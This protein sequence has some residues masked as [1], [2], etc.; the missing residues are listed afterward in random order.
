M[1]FLRKIAP[2]P[3]VKAYHYIL[4]FTAAC[5][6]RFPS[7]RIAVI[8]VTG[9][10]GKSTVVELVSA[11]LEEAGFK[12][13]LAGTI[14]FKVGAKSRPNLFKM[15]MPG[16]FFM[17]KFL[18][19]AV[20]AGCTHAV[21]EMT[22]EGVKQYRHKFIEL[23]AL[24]FTNLAPEHIESHGSFEKYLR[25][26]LELVRA[27]SRSRKKRRAMVANADDPRGS[28]FLSAAGNA[29]KRPY[30]L[31]DAEPF[32][33]KS[34]GIDFAFA[35]TKMHSPLIGQFNLMNILAAATFARCID[36]SIHLIARAVA[37]LEHVPGRVEFIHEGQP[38]QVVVDYAHTPD[39]LRALYEAFKTPSVSH[40]TPGVQRSPGV[41]LIC[42]LGATGGGRDKRK[43]PELG[44]IADA[45]CDIA[46]LTD[47][48]PYD[49][50]PRDIVN[51]VA[52]GFFRIKPE[53]IMDRRE[54]IRKA[55]SL[56][57][58]GDAVLITGKG[59]D[60]FIIRARG[61]KEP[62]SDAQA[63]RNELRR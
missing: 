37:K 15:T 30:R 3:L 48:D 63:A 58:E 47:E 4:A 34:D 38:F 42:V 14:R 7:Q 23:D 12:T 16:R 43:R 62:W 33:L 45:Y 36:I 28:E 50:D 8:G 17:Q 61:A 25:A 27:L 52:G 5:W 56:A 49:E 22:S 24:V 40:K 55:L 35:G 1:P 9:T 13:A 2:E 31:T 20:S 59:T 26:K 46:I 53:V 39:S 41:R 11:I 44:K 54:A 29:E 10:K 51:D 6:Y 60:P 57:K 19:E 21:I 18:R 32:E